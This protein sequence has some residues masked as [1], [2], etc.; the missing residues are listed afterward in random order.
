MLDDKHLL[1]FGIY[2]KGSVENR[3][4][5]QRVFLIEQGR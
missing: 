3:E 5:E 2:G 4:T 1:G